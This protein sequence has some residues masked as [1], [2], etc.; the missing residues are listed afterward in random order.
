MDIKQTLRQFMV[1]EL[2]VGM[3]NGAGT[4]GAAG[5]GDDEDLLLSGL[6][7]SLGVVRLIAFIEAEMGIRVPPEDVTIENFL[8]LQAMS[9][10][11]ERAK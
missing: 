9:D 10:Y 7:D 6:I 5:P 4:G 3:P 11:L 2:L 8:T 1:D